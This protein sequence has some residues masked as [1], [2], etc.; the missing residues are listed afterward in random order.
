MAE[1]VTFHVE[2]VPGAQGWLSHRRGLASG[3]GSHGS[4]VERG[5]LS[6]M[7][8]GLPCTSLEFSVVVQL[9]QPGLRGGLSAMVSHGEL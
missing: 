8:H 1:L 2:S 7:S 3:P 6:A 5:G 9:W 4:L